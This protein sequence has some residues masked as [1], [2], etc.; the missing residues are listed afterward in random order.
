MQVVERRDQPDVARE[1][2]PVAE[3]VARHVADPDDREV[4]LLHVGAELAEVALDRL[5][6]AAGGDA[7]RLV[8][9]A[10]RAAR[11]E[12]VAQPEVVGGRHLV[13]DVR[14]RRRALVRRHDQ[15]GV[16][17]V[18]AHDAVGRHDVAADDVVGDVEHARQEHP[19]AGDPLLQQRLATAARP[20]AA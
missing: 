16:V 18:V 12:R 20:E 9:V 8:V 10:L 14:E 13:G 17:L 7:H 11:R 1:Q 3:H 19:V 2:H 15:V 6:R 4:G 5:P